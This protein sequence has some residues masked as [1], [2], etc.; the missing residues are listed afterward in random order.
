MSA[1][2]AYYALDSDSRVPCSRC[3]WKGV[4]RDLRASLESEEHDIWAY[5]CPTCNEN[6]LL[7]QSPTLLE[8]RAAAA[9]GN[10]RAILDLPKEEEWT[11]G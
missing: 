3:R 1:V 8:I 11:R 2:V 6:V 10:S 9:R 4:V 7:T 5:K